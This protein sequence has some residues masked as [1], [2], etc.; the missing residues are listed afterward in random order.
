MKIWLDDQIDDQDAPERH[1]P[2]GWTGVRNFAEFK[3][4]IERAPP[5]GEPIETIDFDNDLGTDPEGALELD[6]HY[7][8]N[9]LKDTY[10]EYIVGEGIS[11]RVHSRNI[12]ENEAM[13]KDI[14]L[15]RRHP[16]EVLEAKNRPNP[17]GEKEERK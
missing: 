12:I 9:W 14:E 7:I 3:A 16:Q 2:E 4:L 11:L 15:W 10:P 6:G 17:W 5:T 13:R 1:A 8:L